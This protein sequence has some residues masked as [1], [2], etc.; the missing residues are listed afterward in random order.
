[1]RADSQNATCHKNILDEYCAASGQMV[2]LAKSSVFFSPCTHVD[3]RVEVCTTLNIMTE[4]ITD[5][6]LGLPPLVGVDRSDCFQHI[7][8]RV[9]KLLS[10]W[11]EKLLYFG[12]R[13]ILIKAIIQAIPVYAMSVFKL[14]KQICKGIISAMSQFWWGD[15]DQQKHIHWFACGKCASQKIKVA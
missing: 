1:M 9:V 11:K 14:P 12:G 3:R 10:G 13:E 4:A 7:I 6:Y 8:D 2:S 15:D 5:K